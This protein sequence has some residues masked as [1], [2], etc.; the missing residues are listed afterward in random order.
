[1]ALYDLDLTVYRS[2]DTFIRSE[3][4]I[5]ATKRKSAAAFN[6]SDRRDTVAPTNARIIARLWTIA[7]LLALYIESERFRS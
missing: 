2:S 5:T 3:T 1:M 7:T 4:P 6:G